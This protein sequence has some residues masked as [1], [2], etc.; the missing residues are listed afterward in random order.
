MSSKEMPAVEVPAPSTTQAVAPPQ[1]GWRD[2]AVSPW[3]WS[4][5][6]TT[7]QAG[8]HP[9]PVDGEAGGFMVSCGDQGN[10]RAYLKPLKKSESSAHARAAREKICSDLAY[11]LGVDVPP[12]LLVEREGCP[13]HEEQYACVSRVMHPRQWSWMQ[14]KRFVVDPSLDARV[15]GIIMQALPASAARGM[16]L[17]AWVDQADHNDHPHNIIFGYAPGA[18]SNGSFVFL[19]FAW[20]LGFPLPRHRPHGW[21]KE[22]WKDVSPPMFPPHMA[23]YV[24]VD[25]LEATVVAIETM[26]NDLIREIVARIPDTFLPPEQRDLIV[27]G[28]IG[29]KALVR[30]M[31]SAKLKRRT[32]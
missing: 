4:R 11:E 13:A 32:A 18:T 29:R 24:D 23:R 6:A 14:I 5:E 31:L 30:E 9:K 22:A 25:V 3:K 2:H 17:D 7:N 26:S 19:D 28:L 21:S 12:V 8:G 20:S 16:A 10:C 27:E 15:N 1:R